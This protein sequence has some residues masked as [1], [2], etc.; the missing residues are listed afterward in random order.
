MPSR[1]RIPLRGWVGAWLCRLPA[2]RMPFP[3]REVSGNRSEPAS[4]SV[5]QLP[6]TR[7]E[8]GSNSCLDG[9]A[10]QEWRQ[11][12]SDRP[13]RSDVKV[14]AEPDHPDAV[15]HDLASH[16]RRYG[17]QDGTVSTSLGEETAQRGTKH[18]SHDVP[19][20]RSDVAAL[21]ASEP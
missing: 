17:L 14:H 13:T 10:G 8:H 1:K 5:G 21:M 7:Q 9:I 11:A 12:E 15:H 20:G 18:E 19:E 2:C 3:I 4:I 6:R 16:H